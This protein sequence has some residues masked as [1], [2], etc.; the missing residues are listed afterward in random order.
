MPEWLRR[1]AV[2][3]ATSFLLVAA[4][5]GF[6][7]LAACPH[8]GGMLI[9]PRWVARW[10]S[11]EPSKNLSIW[12]GS[13]HG[14]DYDT[15]TAVCTRCWMAY[16]NGLQRWQRGSQVPESF[17]RRLNPVIRNVPLPDTKHIHYRVV[18]W[19]QVEDGQL[20]ESV[21]FWCDDLPEVI[22]PLHAYAVAH[23]LEWDTLESSRDKRRHVE[24]ETTPSAAASE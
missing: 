22:E 21:G 12:N 15:Y 9:A 10:A 5:V 3:L 11:A 23:R 7:L 1:N 17:H 2:G 19:Q 18:Y 24:L 6:A 13:Y 8:C 4:V 14:P 20:K 16:H